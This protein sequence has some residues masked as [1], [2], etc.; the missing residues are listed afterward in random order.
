MRI[1]LVI[2][3]CFIQLFVYQLAYGVELALSEIPVTDTAKVGVILPGNEA[4]SDEIKPVVPVSDAK[5]EV[6]IPARQMRVYYHNEQV[7]EFPIAV[8]AAGFKTPV[9]PREMTQIVWN[10]WWLPPNSSWA[11]DEKPVPPGPRNP[12]GPVKMNLGNAILF[13]GTNKPQSI[14]RAA[15]HG[16]MRMKNEDA[17]TLAWWGQSHF[18]DK[19]DA[20]L[21]DEYL[22]KK[23][24]SFYVSLNIPIPVEIKYEVFEKKNE[25]VIIHPDVYGRVANKKAKFKE[26]L[27]SQGVF[28]ASLSE[29]QIANY[30]SQVKRDSIPVLLNDLM[31]PSM[32]AQLPANPSDETGSAVQQSVQSN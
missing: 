13:H 12:L 5:I 26:W 2:I 25:Q 11:K 20:A 31:I 3:T 15:S 8:G 22:Q 17:K 9:G 24:R 6:N 32:Q 29:T 1:K 7:F 10:P 4:T 16:C 23:G 28:E 14:G 19:T 27:V 21:Q 30:I 18:T